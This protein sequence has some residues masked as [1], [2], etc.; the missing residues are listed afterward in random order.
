MTPADIEAMAGLLGDPEVMAFYPRPKTRAEAIAWIT[1][2]RGLYRDHGY[3]LWLLEDAATGSFV[4]DCGLTL[5]EVDGRTEVEIGYHVVP[6]LQGRGYATEAALATRDFARTVLGLD[7]IVAI[8]DPGNAASRRV[9]EKIGLAVEQEVE[10]SGK[11]VVVYAG[12]P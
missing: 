2:S 3:G 1:W 12:R 8:I 4:G 10:W 11:R 5:Q 6:A 7:R 9:A